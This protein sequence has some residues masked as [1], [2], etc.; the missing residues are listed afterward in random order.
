[1]DIRPIIRS[2]YHA[3][4]DMLAAAIEAC[5][6][7]VWNRPE[8][9]NRTWRVA[10]HALFY[11]HFYLQTTEH[12]FVPWELHRE[13]LEDLGD[14]P[15][16]PSQDTVD[17]NQSLTKAELLAYLAL[18]RRQ[19]DAITP[20]LNLEDASGFH[21][22]PINKL[23]LQLYSMRHVMQHTGELYERLAKTTRVE[24]PWVGRHA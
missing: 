12:S 5:P 22:L 9:A 13:N 2:Q 3:A 18:C 19:V 1:M 15:A 21:W 17:T 10:Y 23:E 6:E 14:W 24:L 16:A 8:D 11:V 20:T 7:P 4:L